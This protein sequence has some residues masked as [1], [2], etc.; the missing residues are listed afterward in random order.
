MKSY[1]VLLNGVTRRIDVNETA[2]DDTYE[3]TL[4]GKMHRCVVKSVDPEPEPD[5]E[6]DENS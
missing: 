1:N 2:I 4:N 3:V 5:E 6:D